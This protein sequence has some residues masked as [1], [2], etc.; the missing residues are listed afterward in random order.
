M[1]RAGGIVERIAGA[2]VVGSNV[3]GDVVAVVG[4]KGSNVL[5][6]GMIAD[7]IVGAILVGAGV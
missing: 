7:R 4:V 2:R 6:V 3:K 1:L 5:G